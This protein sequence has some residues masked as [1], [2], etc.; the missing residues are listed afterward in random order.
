MSA[1]EKFD[2][3]VADAVNTALTSG[4]PLTYSQLIGTL[5]IHNMNVVRIYWAAQAVQQMQNKPIIVPPNGK[6]PPNL[7]RG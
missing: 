6:L 7:G 1:I 4:E 3:A 5:E 2:R